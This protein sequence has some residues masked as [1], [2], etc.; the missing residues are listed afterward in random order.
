MPSPAVNGIVL[1]LAFAAAREAEERAPTIFEEE[2]GVVSE[3]TIAEYAA[4][5]GERMTGAEITALHDLID[6]D[7]RY[8]KNILIATEC[9]PPDENLIALYTAA[10]EMEGLDPLLELVKR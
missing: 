6:E 7:M 1:H 10:C 5:Y 8:R 3:F 9:G 2:N 4:I